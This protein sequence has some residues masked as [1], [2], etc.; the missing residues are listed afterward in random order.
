MTTNNETFQFEA[1]AMIDEDWL[2]W[3]DWLI[4]HST[5]WLPHHSQRSSMSHLPLI[6]KICDP[7]LHWPG[8]GRPSQILDLH[9]WDE[10]RAPL[11]SSAHW[12]SRESFPNW[13]WKNYVLSFGNIPLAFPWTLYEVCSEIC[14]VIRSRREGT[15][16]TGETGS[17]VHI[18]LTRSVNLTTYFNNNNNQLTMQYESAVLSVTVTSLSCYNLQLNIHRI[19]IVAIKYQASHSNADSD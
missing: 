12:S 4:V 3:I 8:F 2:K 13:T 11:S 1:I 18:H 6:D 19:F 17:M 9:S 7:L 15:R 16:D 5:D 10:T 14:L